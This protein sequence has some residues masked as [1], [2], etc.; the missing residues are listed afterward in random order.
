[1]RV[2]VIGGGINGICSAIKI[3]EYLKASGSPVE[4][5]VISEAF[6]PNTTGDGSAGLWGPYLLGGTPTNR[7]HRWSKSMHEFLEQIWLSDD[8][9]EAGVCLIPCIRLTTTTMDND[10]FWK[11]IVYGCQSLTPRQLDELNKGR[12]KKY[13]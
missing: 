13:T 10:V 2:A 8:A 6:S 9:G 11:D 3:L 4:V 5:T 7:V 1:M 12:S